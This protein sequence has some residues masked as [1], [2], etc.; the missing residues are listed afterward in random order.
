ML[1][2]HL[3]AEKDEENG[4]HLYCLPSNTTHDL[5]PMDKGVFQAYEAYWD[6]ELLKYWGNYP[7]R[8]LNTERFSDVFLPTQT[9]TI[10]N[11]TSGFKAVRICPFDKDNLP[12]EAN[13]PSLPTH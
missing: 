12:V 10:S 11:S 4:I 3:I 6:D 13:V 5:Q 7:A 9:M 2:R 1:L 8:V